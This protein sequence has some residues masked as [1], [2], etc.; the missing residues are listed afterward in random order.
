MRELA[1]QNEKLRKQLGTMR[2][3]AL[4]GRR[5]FKELNLGLVPPQPT[6]VWRLPEPRRDSPRAAAERQY[7]T[8]RERR[9]EPN[10]AVSRLRRFCR[11]P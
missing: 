11:R 10:S 4:P 9:T 6:Q 3:P 5:G 2:S 1:D 7:A 8:P